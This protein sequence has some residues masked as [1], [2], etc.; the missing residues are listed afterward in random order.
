MTEVATW[1]DNGSSYNTRGDKGIMIVAS[2]MMMLMMTMNDD[3][4]AHDDDFQTDS[5]S[6]SR[7]LA[8]SPMMLCFV[9]VTDMMI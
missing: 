2:M 1:N 8:N 9:M 5:C 4:N 3:D 7:Y 6:D